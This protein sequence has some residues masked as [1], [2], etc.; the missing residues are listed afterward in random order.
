MGLEGVADGEVEGEAVLE[1]GDVVVAALAG[2]IGGVDAD[3]QVGTNDE[4]RHV[5]TQADTC[6]Q[7]QFVE[8]ILHLQ[9]TTS[10]VIILLQ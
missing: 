2:V 9:L 1:F 7:S 8:E 3:T 4:H 10:T 5:E 6:T